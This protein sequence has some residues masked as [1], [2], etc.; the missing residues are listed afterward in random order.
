MSRLAASARRQDLCLV[1]WCA[2]LACH[3]DLIKRTIKAIIRG[4]PGVLH[5]RGHMQKTT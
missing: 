1:C 4:Q 2:L 5:I 3:A